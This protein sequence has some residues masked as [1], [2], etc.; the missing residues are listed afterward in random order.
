MA[1]A[2]IRGE[3]LRNGVLREYHFAAETQIPESIL[4]INWNAHTETLVDRKVVYSVQ[5]S[6]LAVGGQS[7]VVV[8]GVTGSPVT[9]ASTA[10]G[11]ITDSPKNKVYIRDGATPDTPYK[12]A[13]G[14]VVFGRMTHDGSAYVLSF[15]TDVEGVETAFTFPANKTVDASY[16]KRGN[17]YNM[18]EDAAL[19]GG[20]SSF[21]QGQTDALT[22]FDLKQ[23]ASDLGI[24][25]AHDGNMSLNRSIIAEILYQTA[26]LVNGSVRANEIIDEVVAARNGE[27]SLSVELANIRQS[28]IDEESARISAVTAEETARIA[29]VSAEATTRANA[30]QAIRD[31]LASVANG[32]GGAL[33]VGVSGDAG[34]TGATVED[35]LK[36]LETRTAYLED[37]GGQEVTDTHTREATTANGTF[38]QKSFATLEARLVEIEEVVD[39][40][41]K[42]L[43]DAVD[44]EAS[45]RTSADTTLQGNIDAE[46]STRQSA[47]ETLQD[48]IDAEA[49]ARTSAD[50]TLQSNIN[51]EQSARQSAD[52]TL[53]NNIDAEAST[54]SSADTTLQS[55]IDAEVSARQ[56]A[57]SNEASAR[58]SADTLLQSNIDA[59]ASTRSS[60]DVTLQNNIDAEASTRSSADITLQSNI[61]AEAS[62]R[63][64]GDQTIVSDLA[65]TSNA[66]GASTVGI[67]DSGSLYVASTVEGA[68]AEV[69]TALNQEITDREN[70]GDALLADLASVDVNKGASLV[71]IYDSGAL[72]SA[73][74]VEGALAEVKG[75]L[76]T[77]ISDRQ[78][79]ISD[80]DADLQAEVTRA[81]NAE[82]AI[83]N[84]LASTASGKG[85]TLVAVRDILGNFDGTNVEEVLAELYAKIVA[86]VAAEASARQAAEGAMDTRVSYLEGVAPQIHSHDKYIFTAVGN[87]G[88]VSLPVGKKAD[89]NTLVLTIN[90]LE[91]AEGIHFSCTNDANGYHTGV[92]FSPDVLQANDI[93]IIRWLNV[94]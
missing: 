27:A 31:D 75:A 40:E 21:V 19:G 50:N 71:G 53:Q 85:A 45:A 94:V 54:R 25:L 68:L 72:Y 88:S 36:N 67:E 5:V 18:P 9:S 7:S 3:Q 10:E 2:R 65:S 80:L 79:A 76:N 34:L 81:T 12:D 89:T 1:I 59:E 64:S 74:T 32:D 24:T 20:G 30:D 16:N 37:N 35:V 56:T 62:S 82:Q 44:A 46:A 78:S 39:A 43:E 52:T 70:A 91:Q 29:A 93:V 8:A 38:V 17:L 13:D 4:N 22:D 92:S 41:V 42:A 47:D 26:G 48:N 77:E 86:D 87:E 57:V 28:V 63:L 90:G 84:D 14:N 23:I 66:K 6:D 60:A 33:L 51:A 58:Q 11:V 55:N 83:V 15:F 49:S 61:D 73:T 69:K